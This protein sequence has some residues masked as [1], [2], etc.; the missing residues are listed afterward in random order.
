MRRRRMGNTFSGICNHTRMGNK[1]SKGV[2]C[3]NALYFIPESDKTSDITYTIAHESLES[4]ALDFI[5]GSEDIENIWVYSHPLHEAQL[6]AG[7]LYH[8]FVVL[9]TDEWWWSIEKN[10]GGI[11]LQRSRGLL[12]HAF[13]V[14]ETDEWWWSIEKNTGGI[15]LQRS[16]GKEF[17]KEHFRMEKREEPITLEQSDKG[18]MKMKDLLHSLYEKK[19]V[20]KGYKFD[21]RDMNCLGFAKRVFD[22]FAESKFWELIL[23]Y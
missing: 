5:D 9:E 23:P 22:E 20:R 12:Y 14:L 15:F 11:F 6:T 1:G 7:L 19:E 2:K 13:V 17:V 21:D 18:Q 16:R 8:A 4:C 10:T 3:G